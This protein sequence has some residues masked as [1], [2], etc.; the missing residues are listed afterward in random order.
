MQKKG[1]K[2]VCILDVLNAADLLFQDKPWFRVDDDI[3]QNIAH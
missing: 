1:G 2:V 3:M